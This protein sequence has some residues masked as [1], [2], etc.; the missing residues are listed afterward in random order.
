[1]E[2]HLRIVTVQNQRNKTSKNT[3]ADKDKDKDKD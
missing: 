1:M 2:K 3:F